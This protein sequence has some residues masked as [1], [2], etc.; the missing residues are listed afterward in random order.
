MAR[1]VKFD[2]HLFL[3]LIL[4]ISQLLTE[5]ELSEYITSSTKFRL[6]ATRTIIEKHIRL[7]V[8]QMLDNDTDTKNYWFRA[9]SYGWGWGFPLTWHGWIIVIAYAAMIIVGFFIFPFK[10]KKDLFICWLVGFTIMLLVI[11]WIK[12]EPLHW[13]WGKNKD[14]S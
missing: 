2:I 9:Q 10:E 3:R 12:G 14:E 1:Y 11:C 8:I 5:Y 7:M 6:C 4:R 13:R